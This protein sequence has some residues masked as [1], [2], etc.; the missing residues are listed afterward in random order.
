MSMRLRLSILD[1]APIAKGQTPAESFAASVAL[2]RLAEELGYERV[3]YAEHHNM[4]QI[5]SSAT[6]VVIAHVGAHTSRIRLGAGGI[7]LPNHAP[8]VIAEQF[9][10][11]EAMYPGRIDL[12]LGRA[13]GSDQNTM[14]A[15]GRDPQSAETFPQD[16][17]ELQGYLSGRTRVP[18]VDAVPGKG[19][20]V[21]LY[22]LGSSLFG[23]KLAAAL[24]LPY[25]FASHFAPAALHE[26]IAAYRAQFKPS[27][28]LDAPY[29]IAGC[30]VIA[31]DTATAAADQLQAIR[32]TRAIG[33]F[34]RTRGIS[35]AELELS[36]AEAD[37]LLAAGLAAHVDEMLTYAAVGTPAEVG[38]YLESFGSQT[39][40]DE[41]IVTHQAPRIEDRLRSVTLLAE[42][43]APVVA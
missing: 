24:G 31:A 37:H 35:A 6:S 28:Q 29:V 12:G 43:M 41:L 20:N 5:A 34:A 14:F 13:P 16:V 17:L 32:R 30:N 26:A 25:A 7:M 40:A 21:P 38:E 3:W 4:S 8:L 36:D 15:L 9:G 19:S 2:A 27:E 22:M 23:A 10:T 11:L 18:G 39:G 33:L 1:L 42:A